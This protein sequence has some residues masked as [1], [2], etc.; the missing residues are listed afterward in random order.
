MSISS[1][2]NQSLTP[3]PFRC[4]HCYSPLSTLYQQYRD[5]TNNSL[6]NCKNCNEIAD[7]YIIDN[8][9]SILL[10][11]LSFRREAY[12]HLLY[13]RKLENNKLITTVTVGGITLL[14]DACEFYSSH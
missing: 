4:V 3:F 10:D 8:L 14:L 7:P 9:P 12:G 2:P 6:L 1:P 5:I 11:L 13:N